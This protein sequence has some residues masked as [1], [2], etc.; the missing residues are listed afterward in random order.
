MNPRIQ[1]RIGSR[2]PEDD[3]A[4]D[5]DAVA[6]ESPRAQPRGR[7]APRSRVSRGGYQAPES[8][9][10]LVIGEALARLWKLI[11]LFTIVG[12]A[13]GIGLGIERT[14]L[15][16][17]ESELNAGTLDAQ[18]QA[19][20]G[21]AEAAQTLA[22]AYARV[23][24]T[25][26]IQARVATDTQKSL[27]YVA[28]HLTAVNLPG[29]PIFRI[30]GT[31]PNAAAARVIASA[32]TREIIRYARAKTTPPG[33]SSALDDYAR[34]TVLGTQLSSKVGRLK[35]RYGPNP[36]PGEQAQIST[37][38]RDVAATQL[39]A[40]ADQQLYVNAITNGTSAASVTLLTP[41]AASTSNRKQSIELGGFVGA[42]VG[43][44]I[45]CALAI[46]LAAR[47][48]RQLIQAMMADYETV[49]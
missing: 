39:Q 16:T 15:Y 19:I 27:G 11:L 10:P 28:A 37:A 2:R 44:L 26:Q 25:P 9:P 29:N 32:A 43:C 18:A 8:L 20:P 41:A 40:S 31:G 23:V 35:A 30:D 21:F 13:A 49:A 46:R 38:Q 6:W 1:Q 7:G 17:S 4:T 14:P 34:E 36:S 47:R 5:Q 12:A 22:E 3:P 42:V 48:R 45:G 24:G 33:A